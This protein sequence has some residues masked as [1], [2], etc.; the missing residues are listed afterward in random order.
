MAYLPASIPSTSNISRI[1]LE[2]VSEYSTPGVDITSF[3]PTPSARSS[4][5]VFSFF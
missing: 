2:T 4:N 1:W 3:N 5:V